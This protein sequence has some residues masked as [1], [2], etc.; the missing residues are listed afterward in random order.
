MLLLKI[1]KQDQ[2]PQKATWENR[3]EKKNYSLWSMKEAIDL[4]RDYGVRPL[5]FSELLE[6]RKCSPTLTSINL[7]TSTSNGKTKSLP[8]W[9][10]LTRTKFGLGQVQQNWKCF[11]HSPGR[12]KV[13]TWWRAQLELGKAKCS[14]TR[15]TLWSTK[16]LTPLSSK[17]V[18]PPQKQ[19]CSPLSQQCERAWS[20]QLQQASTMETQSARLESIKSTS[21]K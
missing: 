19:K 8:T 6:K 1:L 2:F 10:A 20:S 3:A 11:P 7:T 4:A 12:E 14:P 21:P 15:W 13:L 9:W 5:G 17:S 18:C 16:L